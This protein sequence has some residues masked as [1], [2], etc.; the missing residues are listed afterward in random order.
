[1]GLRT[2]LCTYAIGDS[3]QQVEESRIF[4]IPFYNKKGVGFS[5]FKIPADILLFFLALKVT[6]QFRPKILYGHLHEG[7]AIAY[8]ISMLLFW[9]KIYV[10]MDAQGGL[11]GELAA[12][13]TIKKNSFSYKVIRLIEAMIVK[14]PRHI[15]CS[16]RSCTEMVNSEF[17][18][19]KSRTSVCPDIVGSHF[20]RSGRNSPSR[21]SL[22]LPENVPLV[23]YTGSL[24]EGKG[25]NELLEAMKF[26]LN[27]LDPLHFALIGYPVEQTESFLK[28]QGLLS[29]VTMLGEQDYFKLQEF[30]FVSDL[31]VDPKLAESSEAS[32]KILHY[33]A[34]GLPVVCFDT[35]N[36][37]SLLPENNFLCQNDGGRDLGQCILTAL[38]EP[39]EKR[40]KIGE[41]NRKC[42]I[43]HHTESQCIDV[44]TRAF[45]NN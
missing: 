38:K 13:G 6:F 17:S 35:A 33:M 21:S 30:L 37:R 25:L 41:L 40:I 14:M 5:P 34:A 31:A 7:A 23:I 1:M 10:V 11:S 12:Y 32:G 36:N 28:S 8:A 22:G 26:S 24:L 39:R 4:S 19:P 42:I 29:R 20:F 2:H 27:N 15:T 44:L 43:D 16:S 18:V 3:L 45:P 9:R